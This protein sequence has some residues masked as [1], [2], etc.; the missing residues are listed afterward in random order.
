M[1]IINSDVSLGVQVATSVTESFV[2]AYVF[3]CA[4]GLQLKVDI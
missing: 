1:V 3:G 4:I 2:K